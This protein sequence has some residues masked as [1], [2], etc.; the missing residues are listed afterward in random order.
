MVI[1]YIDHS[2][3]VATT[4]YNT[5]ADSHTT[6]HSTL[7][8]LSLLS[9]VFTIRILATDLSQPR[10]NVKYHCN[11]SIRTVFNSHTKSSWHSLIP[12]IV[13]S[14]FWLNSW[15]ITIR[16]I[17]SFSDWTLH[18]NYSDFEIN[19]QLLLASRNIYFG[20]DL[21][22]NASIV[23]IGRPLATGCLPRICLRGKAFIKPLSSTGSTGHNISPFVRF[24]VQS[25]STNILGNWSHSLHPTFCRVV[26]SSRCL[27]FSISPSQS[28]WQT[29]TKVGMNPIPP[30]DRNVRIRRITN[31]N[32]VDAW[33]W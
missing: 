20:A 11:Y 17:S 15:Q 2:Q 21:T 24:G 30:P 1:G 33:N 4:K 6:N 22:E 31:N 23:Y 28:V 7:N 3:V 27:C 19:S 26:S 5:L 13:D 9:L 14:L 10:R 32:M 29:F 25:V 18:W 12:S 8:L 16:H